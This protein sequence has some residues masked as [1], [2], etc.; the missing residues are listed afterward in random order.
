MTI[1]DEWVCVDDDYVHHARPSAP[2]DAAQAL[3]LTL[4]HPHTHT[5]THTHTHA[6]TR[7]RI[8]TQQTSISKM[9][10]KHISP[11]SLSFSFSK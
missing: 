11:N 4:S 6:H 10:R 3:A 8:H 2:K 1:H 9:A 5:H 7:A